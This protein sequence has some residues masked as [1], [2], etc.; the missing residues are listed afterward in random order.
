MV[1]GVL[2]IA[3]SVWFGLARKDTF[4]EAWIHILVSCLIAFAGF[5]FLAGGVFWFNKIQKQQQNAP[6]VPEIPPQIMPSSQ[7]AS[8]RCP[9]YGVVTGPEGFN[10]PPYPA[11][12][13]NFSYDNSGYAAP[14][15][16]PAAFG[17]PMP[18]P[19]DNP[20]P[21]SSAFTYG[22]SNPAAS[23]DK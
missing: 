17:M 16:Y 2:M 5:C 6:A 18:P 22:N 10:P 12:P 7:D 1:G 23:A 8:A 20:P 14:P 19:E 15:P 9:Q 11:T 3:M 13:S 4:Q 21:Y